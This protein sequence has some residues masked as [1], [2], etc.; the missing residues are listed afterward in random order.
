MTTAPYL[1]NL[2]RWTLLLFI[3]ASLLA[4]SAGAAPKHDKELID[5]HMSFSTS[6]PLSPLAPIAEASGSDAGAG[7]RVASRGAGQPAATPAALL[8][9][10]NGA[11]PQVLRHTFN[12]LQTGEPQSLCQFR[13]K[14][15]LVVNTAS[16]CGYTS[17]YEGLEALYR[18]YKDRGLVVVGFPTNDFGS[19]EPGTNKEIAEFCRT[20]YGIQ[21]PMFEKTTV[22]RL[23]ANP[24]YATLI[25]Q[26]GQRPRW[27]FHKYV[28]DRSGRSVRSFASDT[29]PEQKDL[30]G[31]I[32]RLLAEKP[33]ATQG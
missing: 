11:C 4:A 30:V 14:V 8:A 18:K 27:N 24:F 22:G 28:I 19:Q 33:G 6:Q 20:T 25:E 2:H 31:L 3:A 13:G 15:L 12:R 1:S 23:D 10:D 7:G 5:L 16:F 29:T 32:E 17:Q 26:S 9:M 21:F